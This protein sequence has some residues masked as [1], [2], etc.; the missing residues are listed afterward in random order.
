MLKVDLLLKMLSTDIRDLEA[1]LSTTFCFR[2]HHMRPSSSDPIAALAALDEPTRRRLYE[3][4]VRAGGPVGHDEASKAVGVSRPTAAFHLNRLAEEGLLDVAFA[5]LSGRTGPGAG[6]PAKLYSRSASQV[7]VSLPERHYDVVGELF[8]AAGR[9]IREAVASRAREAGRRIGAASGTD[10][11]AVLEEQGYEPRIEAGV[12]RLGNCPFHD[13]AQRHAE[14][15]CAMN[16]DLLNGVLDGLEVNDYRAGLRPS[17][18]LCCVVL[19]AR[20]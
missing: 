7:E 14:L 6:R 20:H 5:R 1:L 18:G 19:T 15:V 9:P 8:A 2:I 3:Y 4:V 13:L 16:L 17:P 12:V 11:V 10:L